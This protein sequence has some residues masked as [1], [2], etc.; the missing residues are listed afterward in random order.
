MEA[1]RDPLGVRDENEIKLFARA[2]EAYKGRKWGLAMVAGA[3][4]QGC[5]LLGS[6]PGKPKKRPEA[7]RTFQHLLPPALLLFLPETNNQRGL[8]M[9]SSFF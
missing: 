4:G 9:S 3:A 6:T 1:G 5:L 2:R 7:S 8:R